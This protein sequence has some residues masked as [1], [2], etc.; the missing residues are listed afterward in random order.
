M[1]D[2]ELEQHH[3]T[4]ADLI[5]KLQTMPQDAKVMT[6]YDGFCTVDPDHVFVARGGHVIMVD[7]NNA[8]Y[9]E[10]DRPEWAPH[11]KDENN[12]HTPKLHKR[13]WD[14]D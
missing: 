1:E 2:Y 10:D 9:R 5:A 11:E 6:I 7:E 14:P 12:W 3:V 8:V 4:V 13:P